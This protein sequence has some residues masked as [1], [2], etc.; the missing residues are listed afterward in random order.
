MSETVGRTLR[1]LETSSVIAV[2]DDDNGKSVVYKW[3][4]KERRA[5]YIPWSERPDGKKHILFKV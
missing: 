1:T 2:K 5:S 3:L 4:P